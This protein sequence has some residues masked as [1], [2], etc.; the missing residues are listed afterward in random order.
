MGNFKKQYR[1]LETRV[2]AELRDRISKS[3]TESKHVQEKSIQVNVFDYTELAIINDQLTFLGDKGQHYSIW[4][5]DC[6]L[7]DFVDILSKG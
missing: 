6:E 3:K 1:D 4:N 2:L 5:G 7:E